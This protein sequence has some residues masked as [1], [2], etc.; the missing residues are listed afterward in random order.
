LRYY[1]TPPSNNE[2][3]DLILKEMVSEINKGFKLIT[4]STEVELR[5]Y[6]RTLMK[7]SA[8]LQDIYDITG[9]LRGEFGVKLMEAGPRVDAIANVISQ[10]TYL[11]YT[12]V[13]L[14][15]KTIQG[16]WTLAMGKDLFAGL[17]GIL[18][19]VTITEKR[20]QIPWLKWALEEGNKI[21]IGSFRVKF[22][23]GVGRSGLAIMIP[24]KVVGWRIPPAFAG[25]D[26]D[27]WITREVYANVNKYEQI[28]IKNIKKVL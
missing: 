8:F 5:D 12:P 9:D 24:N 14:F 1:V 10:D 3:E 27:N 25:T 15:G 20:E 26:Y 16:G 17:K 13:T 6:T 11:L 23:V 19:G 2:L 28:L 22:R 7:R 21:I 4:S 18:A